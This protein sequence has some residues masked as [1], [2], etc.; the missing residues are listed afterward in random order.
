MLRSMNV[1]CP[2][3]RR[4]SAVGKAPAIAFLVGGVL[5]LAQICLP[6]ICFAQNESGQQATPVPAQSVSRPLRNNT[7]SFTI[8]VVTRM[9]I[10]EV[11]VRDSEDNPVR[12][13]TANDLQ[14]TE[15]ID[16]SKELA[17]KIAT[18]RAVTEP[19]ARRLDN[20]KGIVLGW[21]HKSFCALTGPTSFPITFRPIA[22]R[23]GCTASR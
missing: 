11:V 1:G 16:D 5:C 7:P 4:L 10:V 9:V 3:P 15:T 18:L 8:K 21:L 13:L 17:E 22:A 12:D 2:L 14:V 6:Q 23:M 20:S 19:L